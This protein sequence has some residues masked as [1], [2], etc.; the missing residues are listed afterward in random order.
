VLATAL[1][2]RTDVLGFKRMEYELT[3]DAIELGLGAALR[4]VFELEQK[5]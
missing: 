3:P 2:A 5:P 4:A 1:F